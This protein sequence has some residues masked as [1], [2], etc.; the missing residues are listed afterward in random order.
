MD[1]RAHP[2]WVGGEGTCVPQL[3]LTWAVAGGQHGL[4]T[5]HGLLSCVAVGRLFLGGLKRLFFYF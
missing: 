2:R 3:S 4:N 5:T 1:L